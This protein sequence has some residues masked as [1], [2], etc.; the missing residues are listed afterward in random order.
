VGTRDVIKFLAKLN[1]SISDDNALENIV[2]DYL[3][4]H[5]F[6]ANFF[7]LDEC[8]ALREMKAQAKPRNKIE[9]TLLITYFLENLPRKIPIDHIAIQSGYEVL[10]EIPG[11]VY[12]QLRDL[13]DKSQYLYLVQDSRGFFHLSETGRARVKE[14]VGE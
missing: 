5:P 11:A 13:K 9:T 10:G 12:N 8:E 7:T 6:K 4:I 1:D 2:N 14:L 3:N